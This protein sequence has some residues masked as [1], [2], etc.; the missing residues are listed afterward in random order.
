MH[1][2]PALRNHGLPF[3]PFKAIVA[4]RPIGWISSLDL[5]GRVN[6]APYSY[7]NAFSDEP[8]IIGFGS[9]GYKDSI[10]NIAAT[11]EFVCNMASFDLFEKMS[12]TSAPLPPG[13]S[14]MGHAGLDPATS[15][16][17]KPPRIAGVATALECKLLRIEELSDLD[18]RKTGSYLVLGQV[19]SVY[20]DD[21]FLKDGKLDTAAIKP[22]ARL[23]YQDYAAIDRVFSLARPSGAG[24][25][26]KLDAQKLGAQKLGAQKL[27]AK[28]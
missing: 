19:I 8:P 26:Q 20:I 3:N 9:S 6:L 27:G 10:S 24:D 11:G 5:A 22:L 14:E 7:F 16:R 28:V 12:L 4:P 23:G 2:D 18:G 13:E 17:V 21:R 25:I 1:Y 15:T